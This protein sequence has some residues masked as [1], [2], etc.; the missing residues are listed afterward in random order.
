MIKNYTS[1]INHQCIKTL[2]KRVTPAIITGIF[3][4]LSI[5]NISAQEPENN[6]IQNQF[7]LYRKNN[8]EEKIFIHTDK[9]IYMPGE[10]C[11]FNIYNV[12]AFFHV[13]SI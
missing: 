3:F 11:W 5:E 7:D 1:V 2:I 6:I 4:L 8:L 9:N 10:I 13:Y 12:D